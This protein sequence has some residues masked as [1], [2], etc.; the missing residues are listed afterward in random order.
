MTNTAQTQEGLHEPQ[1]SVFD[2]INP[3]SK[4]LMTLSQFIND[5]RTGRFKKEIEEI[6][7]EPDKKK[8]NDL[9]KKLLAVSPSGVFE[10]TRGNNNNKSYAPQVC[11]DL[12]DLTNIA[13]ARAKLEGDEF[14]RALALSPSG[15]GLKA[16]VIVPDEPQRH[17]AQVKELMDYFKREYQLVA[18]EKC[19]DVSRLCFVTYDP[20]VYDNPDASVFTGG[21]SED[22]PALHSYIG[23]PKDYPVDL[24]YKAVKNEYG[25]V[26]Y[27]VIRHARFLQ[28]LQVLGFRRFDLGTG[29]VFVRLENNIIEE[30]P[31]TIIQDAFFDFIK[32]LPDELPEG[33]STELLYEKLVKSPE[34]LFSDMKLSI[35]ERIKPNFCKDSAAEVKFFY[36][37]GFVKC[38]K[39]GYTLH[40]YSE[41]DGLVWKNQ[42][43]TRDFEVAVTDYTEVESLPD[44]A[45]FIWNVSGKD[46]ERFKAFCT[47]IGNLLHDHFEG[48]TRVA[49]LTDSNVTPYAN[50]RTGKTLFAKALGQVTPLCEING[51]DFNPEDRF[52]YQEVE[53]S[54]TLVHINDIDKKT[55]IEKFFVDITEGI[56]VQKKN[57]Q[58]FKKQ[59]RIIIST[60]RTM[61][62]EGA[63]ARDRVIEIEFSNHYSETFSPHTEFGKWFFGEGWTDQDWIGSDNFICFCVCLYLQVGVLTPSQINLGRRKLLAASNEEFID[64]IDARV[65]DGRINTHVVI[66]KNDLRD[67]FLVEY[68]EHRDTIKDVGKVTTWLRHYANLSGHFAPNEPRQDEKAANGKKYFV[69]RPLGYKRTALAQFVA[70]QVEGGIELI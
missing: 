24:L 1:F 16:F 22:L 60:N 53:Y 7:R 32:G 39:E 47:L 20:D 26:K 36:K 46:P 62:I 30:V 6:R 65:K 15:T 17:K 44:F 59:V 23:D 19:S 64:F 35:I 4:G 56:S 13:E 68:P 48:K 67:E 54:D 42:I 50:G 14:I 49:I 27:I 11:L 21:T 41:T 58:P 40:P 51:K 52:K 8:R 69:F 5:I 70:P 33:V 57:K 29:F 43:L 28:L 12:D 3:K 31:K 55:S 34:N 9:K 45:K 10:Q 61:R 2:G 38:T 18:D 63:S 66:C 37:N 25:N